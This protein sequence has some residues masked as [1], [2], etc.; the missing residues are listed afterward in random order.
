MKNLLRILLVIV[1]VILMLPLLSFSAS[2]E[3]VAGEARTVLRVGPT[4]A[5]ALVR[6]SSPSGVSYSL[7]WGTALFVLTPIIC[8]VAAAKLGKATRNERHA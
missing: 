6:S 4:S 2:R 5:P 1:G 7:S 8:F 3:G